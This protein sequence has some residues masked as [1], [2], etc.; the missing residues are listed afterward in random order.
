M[1]P[2][3]ASRQYHRTSAAVE[4]AQMT[5]FGQLP[6]Y[7]ADADRFCSRPT[8][9]RN[10]FEKTIKDLDRHRPREYHDLQRSLHL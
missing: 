4:P 7:P 10:R 3:V 8:G 5:R 9:A 6:I 1:R 2:T